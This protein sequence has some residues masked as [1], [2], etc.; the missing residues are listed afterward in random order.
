MSGR[1][2]ALGVT[3][4]TRTRVTMR[5]QLTQGDAAT[6]DRHSLSI[7]SSCPLCPPCFLLPMPLLLAPGL[8]RLMHCLNNPTA[9]PLDCILL[10]PL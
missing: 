3:D 2:N 5:G 4:V 8:A 10:L 1:C 7:P 9:V 6:T